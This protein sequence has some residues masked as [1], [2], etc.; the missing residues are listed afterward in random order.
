M[1]G[2]AARRQPVLTA[3]ASYVGHIQKAAYTI[4]Q[5]QLHRRYNNKCVKLPREKAV[6]G[7]LVFFTKTYPTSSPV[8]HIGIYVGNGRMLHCGDPIGYASI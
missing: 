8:T 5:E 4:C 2:V 6:A 7:D 1:F 3:P